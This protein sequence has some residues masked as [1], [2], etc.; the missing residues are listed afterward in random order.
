MTE[1]CATEG[2]FGAPQKAY[3]PLVLRHLYKIVSLLVSHRFVPQ[4][5]DLWIGG[6]VDLLI[7]HRTVAYATNSFAWTWLFRRTA[8]SCLGSAPIV[9]KIIWIICMP[10]LFY[11]DAFHS[12]RYT[13]IPLMG[14]ISKGNTNDTGRSVWI[15]YYFFPVRQN[16]QGEVKSE[17]EADKKMH[18]CSWLMSKRCSG[19]AIVL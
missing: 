16:G 18:W 19:A 10:N 14:S 13:L 4:R 3:F 15:V 2:I 8:V 5:M 12:Q 17:V 7:S 11:P 9:Y 6:G 1:I